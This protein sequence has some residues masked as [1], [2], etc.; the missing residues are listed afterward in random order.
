MAISPEK[1]YRTYSGKFKW[2]RL[3][4][5]EGDKPQRLGC[6]ICMSLETNRV[7]TSFASGDF[8]PGRYLYARTFQQHERQSKVHQEAVAKQLPTEEIA[9]DMLPKEFSVVAKVETV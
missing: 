7:K 2:L 8:V 4:P 9:E 5:E 1:A 3:L 6:H